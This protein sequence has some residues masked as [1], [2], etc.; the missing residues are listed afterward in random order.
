MVVMVGAPSAHPAAVRRAIWPAAQLPDSLDGPPAAAPPGAERS[1]HA[2]HGRLAPS[3]TLPPTCSMVSPST[4]QP[5]AA[6]VGSA[7]RR[8]VTGGS[9]PIAPL[10]PPNPH[11]AAR[12]GGAA[13]HLTS[14]RAPALGSRADPAPTPRS[15]PGAPASAWT[16]PR[17]RLHGVRENWGR[18]KNGGGKS[19][20]E[21]VCGKSG[22]AG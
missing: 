20:R 19:R 22:K 18:R 14:R 13:R 21:S 11:P 17:L 5:A 10:S 12:L 9:V 6:S 16:L 2:P 7:S 8:L 1:H 4:R 3:A 15:V